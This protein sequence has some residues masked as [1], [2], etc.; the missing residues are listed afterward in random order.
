MYYGYKIV[1]VDGDEYTGAT[2]A[3]DFVEAMNKIDDYYE[4]VPAVKVSIVCLTEDECMDMS[5]IDDDDED[6]EDDEVK[7]WYTA[8]V[9][10]IPTDSCDGNFTITAHTTVTPHLDVQE[11]INKSDIDKLEEIVK[12]LEKLEEENR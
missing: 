9:D 10:K 6:D 7:D 2:Y 3:D 11:N 4:D 5:D 12:I 8:E 1:D